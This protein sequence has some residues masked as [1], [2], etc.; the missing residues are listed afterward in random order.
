WVQTG[1]TWED[2]EF[3]SRTY[4]PSAREL[5]LQFRA[6]AGPAAR[7][8]YPRSPWIPLA[9]ASPRLW[10]LLGQ[11]HDCGL[12]LVPGTA[13]GELSVRT[14]PAVLV[15]DA[16][17]TPDGLGLQP[18]V[19]L[20]GAP[21]PPSWFGLLGEPAHGIFAIPD[22]QRKA[23]LTLAPLAEPMGKELRSLLLDGA[24][25]VVPAADE[26]RFAEEFYPRLRVH[27]PIV[28]SDASIALPEPAPPILTCAVHFRPEHRLRIDWAWA[29]VVG[30]ERRTFA[31]EEAA[32]WPTVRDPDAERRLLAALPLPY[33]S[34]PALRPSPRNA[35]PAAHA[36][37][38][39]RHAV[40]FVE[41]VVPRLRE[42]GVEVT[43]LGEVVDYRQVDVAPLIEMSTADRDD[44][45]DWFDLHLR[46]SVEGEEIGFDE[47]FVALAGDSDVLITTSGVCVS[48]DRPEFAGLRTLI[49]EART[50][51]ER[52][53]P[54]GSPPRLSISKF[55]AGLWEELLQLGIVIDQSASW[56][57]TVG[58]LI[59]VEGVEQLPVPQGL[60]AELR[61]YQR[62]GYSWLGFLYDHGLGGILADD[63]GLGKTV[64]AL[65]LIC[66]AR[67]RDPD[68]APFLVL[69]PTSVV[70]TWA[71]E[72]ERFAPGLRVVTVER[73]QAKRK[74]PLSEIVAG[75]DLVITSY[76]LARI[77]ADAYAAPAW[78]GLVLDEAQFVKN[79]RAKTYAV[80]RRIRA[81]FK[82]A[83]TGTP[84]ENSLMDLWAL[85]SIT[86]PGL[87][88]HP[89]RF[90]E[91]YSRP[92][93]R[94]ADAEL[95]ARLRRRIRPLMLRRTKEKVASELPPKQEQVLE[96]VLEPK[97]RRIYAT[98]LQRERQK[99]LGLIDELD[100]NRF[101]I[102]RSLTLLRQLALD[103]SL[104]DPAYAGVPASK[105][106]V[107]AE[108]L[109]E[110]VAE[111]HQA[112]V[113]S[114]FT[115]FL[116]SVRRRLDAEQI[117]YSYLDGRTR[118][119][120]K[121]VGEFRR[122]DT[123]VFLIS[124]K[125]GGFG[126]TLTEADYCFVLDPW[127]NPASE[128]QA[129]DRAHRIGQDKSVLVYRLVAADTIEEKVMQLKDRKA[130]LFTS[131]VGEDAL[132]DASLTAE[133]I[134]GL[135]GA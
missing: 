64:Q 42:V 21:L 123:R 31:L 3:L 120:D 108:H 128:A 133:E 111:G 59:D 74:V 53:E 130:K 9:T 119:R 90:A 23:H 44:S 8:G 98:H 68:D 46:V 24:P 13:G 102:L 127:W 11:A 62:E 26:R 132:A 63:M 81:P 22:P 73:S 82:L 40:L 86:A 60:R 107:L 66:R 89:E 36:L 10:S 14:E 6:A 70:S 114:Q 57:R 33:A 87:F 110:L 54:A 99:V 49:E 94:S 47:L 19:L 5:L 1:V 96:V 76:T 115:G 30:G 15:L 72:A 117:S 56:A 18:R 125:A 79:H 20:D 12:A 97:H 84:L 113:F 105:V 39:D 69:A 118:R 65:A 121:V 129:V 45:A 25:V 51:T 85:L 50:L 95:L 61:S 126:L 28:S 103:P 48:L 37:L 109:G 124:L 71:K 92:I 52:D 41:E 16:S 75:A 116:A 27:A 58:G 77:D 83:I 2:L 93:E 101:T 4:A 17:R 91:T 78:S 35:A 104:V 32:G 29:Y 112:L 34:I 135:F 43:L 106:E 134:R 55:Q 131:V 7:Y 67:A 38:A 80:A 100:K 88:P 122:G